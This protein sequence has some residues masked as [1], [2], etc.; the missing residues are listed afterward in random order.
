MENKEETTRK[1]RLWL[2]QD[3]VARVIWEPGAEVTLDD[4]RET[5]AAYLKINKGKRRPLL[6]DTK[7]MR[8]LARE[9]RSYYAGE[10]AAS[11]ASAVAILVGTP[12]SRVLGNFYIGLSNPRLPSR[13]FTSEGEALKWL[14]RYLE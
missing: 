6:I 1:A 4:A 8:S 13:L 7:T 2:G 5:M 14:K 10:E 3:G 11:V 9:A 12:V